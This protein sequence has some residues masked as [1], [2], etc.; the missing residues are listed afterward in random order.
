MTTKIKDESDDDELREMKEDDENENA[1]IC[2][3]TNRCFKTKNMAMRYTE[4]LY[5]AQFHTPSMLDLHIGE[6]KGKKGCSLSCLMVFEN[7]N[8]WSEF[9]TS[10]FRAKEMTMIKGSMYDGESEDIYETYH[11]S[12]PSISKLSRKEKTVDSVSQSIENDRKSNSSSFHYDESENNE[13]DNSIWIRE[14]QD[15]VLIFSI[16]LSLCIFFLSLVFFHV[17]VI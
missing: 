14:D 13:S 9:C 15:N 1:Q 7:K 17:G 10:S 8:A 16:G 12:I 11:M 5:L 2:V 4:L 3:F 6:S